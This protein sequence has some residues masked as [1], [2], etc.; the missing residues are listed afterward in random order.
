MLPSLIRPSPDYVV[1]FLSIAS[2]LS[3]S[4]EVRAMERGER[5]PGLV[6]DH[7]RVKIGSGAITF[8]RARNAIRTWRMFDMPWLS[9]APKDAPILIGTTV[10]IWAKTF[11]AWTLNP[12]RIV[13]SIDEPGP[14]ERFGF[15]YASLPGHAEEGIESFVVE[16]NHA[17]DSVWYDLHAISRP[18]RW[19]T[20]LIQPMARGLQRRFARDSVTAMRSATAQETPG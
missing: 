2:D 1:R 17:D 16:W 20:T 18:G 4:E 7:N 13:A 5:S 11:G 10:V 14:V 19:F 3:L 9:V 12:A 8:D 15:T 6:E